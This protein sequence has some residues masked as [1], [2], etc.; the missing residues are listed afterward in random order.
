MTGLEGLHWNGFASGIPIRGRGAYHRGR[1][2]RQGRR[3]SGRRSLR[4][5]SPSHPEH[6]SSSDVSRPARSRPRKAPRVDASFPYRP[7]RTVH[8]DFSGRTVLVMGG[9]RVARGGRRERR[10]RAGRRARRGFRRGRCGRGADPLRPPRLRGQLRRR[11]LRL[12]PLERADQAIWDDVM[13]VNAR[14]VWLSMRH[15]IPAMLAT[16]GGAVVNISSIYGLADK[17]TIPTT[18][19]SRPARRRRAD[20]IGHRFEHADRGVRVNAVCAGVTATTAM[21]QAENRVSAGSRPR[22]HRGAPDGAHGERGG[23]RRRGALA[24]LAGRE[25]RDGR[26]DLQVDGGFLAA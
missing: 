5:P 16:G 3:A 10:L 6:L 21:R 2:R 4:T 1:R 18:P 22:A 17:A 7:A 13:S 26:G 11:R 14:G 20:A 19:M 25:V 24:L 12:A 23:D 8:Y 15:E 9:T